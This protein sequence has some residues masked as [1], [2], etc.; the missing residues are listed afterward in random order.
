MHLFPYK[1]YYNTRLSVLCSV[2]IR[3]LMN[4]AKEKVQGNSLFAT[5]LVPLRIVVD[6]FE[7]WVNP[8]P[9]SYRFCRPLHIQYEKE[10]ANLILTEKSQVEKQIH[11]L[12]PISVKTSQGH[13]V[14]FSC[15]LTLSVIDGKVLNIIT[16]TSSQFRCP[17]CKITASQF[18]YLDLAQVA[19]TAKETMRHGINPLHAWIRILE[20]LLHLSYK[21]DALVR[22][23][24]INKN[25]KE[26][27]IGERRK[28]QVQTDLRSKLGLLVDVVKSNS[29]TT[30]DGNTAKTALSDKNQAIFTDILGLE[31]WLVEGL[32]IVLVTISCEFA[33]DAKKFG[34]F[35]RTLAEKYVRFYSWH[36][37]TVTVH[38][39]LMHGEEIIASSALPIGMLSEQAAES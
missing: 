24:R 22:K 37:M 14:T 25:S 19:P 9:Q 18:N 1:D 8:T 20:F 29:G 21:N 38:K 11:E 35:C 15:D 13:N 23:W 4:T 36:P 34:N 7:I 32:H 39:I 16:G 27:E 12:T 6:N 17:F 5:T 28:I 10:T 30:N 26:S 31:P 33:I 2:V 3:H